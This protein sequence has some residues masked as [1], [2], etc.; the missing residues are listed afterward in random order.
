[1]KFPST[2]ISSVY[3]S[4]INLMAGGFKPHCCLDSS[5]WITDFGPPKQMAGEPWAE[6]GKGVMIFRKMLNILE[7]LFV[8]CPEQRILC[9]QC[10]NFQGLNTLPLMKD[11]PA[12][13]SSLSLHEKYLKD[14]LHRHYRD[15]EQLWFVHSIH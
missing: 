2:A 5:V 4:V 9:F 10:R 8:K 15:Q 13:A 1:M 3:L 6:I 12:G 14:N 11:A 7:Q